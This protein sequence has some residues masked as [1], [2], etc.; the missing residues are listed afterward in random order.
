M[1]LYKNKRLKD[2]AKT[3]STDFKLIS[4]VVHAKHQSTGV[5]ERIFPLKQ[6]S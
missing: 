5:V 3:K 2:K 1:N 4:T 6:L